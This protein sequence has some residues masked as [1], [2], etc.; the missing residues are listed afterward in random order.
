MA[1]ESG[2]EACLP[3]SATSDGG[4]LALGGRGDEHAAASRVGRSH[5]DMGTKGVPCTALSVYSMYT[6]CGILYRGYSIH[7][8]VYRIYIYDTRYSTNL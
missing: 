8:T 7:N 1:L 5:Q 6:V 2:L 4:I 3:S